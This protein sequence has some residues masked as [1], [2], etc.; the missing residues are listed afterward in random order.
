M[1]T[2]PQ[3]PQADALI[4]LGLESID[5]F[6]DTEG[7]AYGTA[8]I[9]ERSE[10]V[11]VRSSAFLRHLGRLYWAKH[12]AAANEHSLDA[13]RQHLLTYAQW[14]R[15]ERPIAVRVARRSEV[16]FVD[17]ADDA[18]N[19]VKIDYSGWS[20]IGAKDCPVRFLRPRG[21]LALPRPAR[22]GTL[23]SL[24]P[25][26]NL[27][28]EDSWVLTSAWLC[29]TM[30][31]SP[32]PL[33][34]LNGTQDSGKSATTRFLRGVID[35]REGGLRRFPKDEAGLFLAA[36]HAHVLAFDNLSG[37]PAPIADA[38]CTLA[39]GEGYGTRKLYTDD[40]EVIFKGARP[41]I[42]NGIDDIGSRPDLRD[43][44]IVL[45]L[46]SLDEGKRRTEAELQNAF[47][48]AHPSILGAI[49]KVASVGLRSAPTVRLDRLP[50]MAD[51]ARWSVAC[52]SA[53]GNPPGTFLGAY[54]RNRSEAALAAIDYSPVAA[55]IID[56]LTSHLAGWAGTATE[57]LASL[58]DSAVAES[59]NPDW[60]RGAKA[61][62]NAVRRI[63]PA[64]RAVGIDVILPTRGTGRDHRREFRFR[65]VAQAA[66]H[67]ANDAQH[68]LP[69]LA[70][71]PKTG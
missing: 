46:S 20:V 44:S 57:L 40:E 6:H 7:I 59:G 43:R 8:R 63:A 28:D 48:S 38:L 2:N 66:A 33:L 18:D 47:R 23:E 54:R 15:P 42:L 55:A 64:L 51:F 71:L 69:T 35:P 60:P 37:V 65:R 26:L 11:E 12:S 30:G 34:A 53:I 52:E 4:A 9:G 36:R 58:R 3:S 70:S 29:G 49:F 68:G 10:T 14:E 1:T 5:L 22:E 39:Y 32:Y 67:D 16:I 45:S 19:V 61:L 31:V 17:L 13:A 41:I 24:R 27:P 25:F 21:T 50:R 62:A 56:L